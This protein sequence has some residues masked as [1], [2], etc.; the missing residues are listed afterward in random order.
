MEILRAVFVDCS[1]M[2]RWHAVCGWQRRSFHSAIRILVFSPVF[3]PF[4]LLDA[5]G[6]LVLFL[7][8]VLVV[9]CRRLSIEWCASRAKLGYVNFA[10]MY[11]QARWWYVFLVLALPTVVIQVDNAGTLLWHRLL[12]IINHV[13]MKISV[14]C[15]RYVR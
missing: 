9:A 3:C 2:K 4:L 7:P 15:V 14:T 13:L 10:K 1:G 11:R 8:T 5:L 12:G 6:I